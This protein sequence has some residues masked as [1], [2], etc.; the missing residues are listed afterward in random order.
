ML[1][2]V[3]K[4]PSNSCFTIKKLAPFKKSGYY[5][6][7]PDCVPNPLRV[8]CDFDNFKFGKD[9][10]YY[11]RTTSAGST[12]VDVKSRKDALKQCA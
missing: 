7:K 6:I 12:A 11:G 2:T 9:L 4:H 10:A 5:W 8:F 1:G 3:S